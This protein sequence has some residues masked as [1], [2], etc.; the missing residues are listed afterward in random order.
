MRHTDETYR[1]ETYRCLET[2]RLICLVY[3]SGSVCLLYV[4]VCMSSICL[5]LYVCVLRTTTCLAT[6]HTHVHIHIYTYTHTHVHIHVYTYTRVNIHS[7]EYVHTYTR[8]LSL[9]HVLLADLLLIFFYY[10]YILRGTQQN[11][12]GL[13]GLVSYYYYN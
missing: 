7:H 8:V 2:Y 5:G 13:M 3:M 4:W 6:T 1:L 11:L 9:L 10:F 12:D